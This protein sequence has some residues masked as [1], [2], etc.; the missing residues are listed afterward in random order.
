MMAFSGALF[1]Q[2]GAAA[3]PQTAAVVAPS[4]NFDVVSIR[5]SKDRNA[6]RTHSAPA[7]G[8]GM[9]FTNVP[10][11]MVILTA[12]D[13]NNYTL[14]MGLP[15]WTITD[16]YDVAVKVSEADVAAYH[17]LTSAQRKLMLRRVLEDR[18][19]LNAHLE[20][21]PILVYDLVVAKNGPK[22]K[23]AKPGDTYPNGFKA[24]AG[25]TVL[26]SPPS[27]LVGQGASVTELANRMSDMGDYSIGRQVFDKTGLTGKYDFSLQWTP[28]MKGAGDSDSDGGVEGSGPSLR[29]S[30]N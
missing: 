15:D 2:A 1:A 17:A 20:P 25:Q 21:R 7:N 30:E 13:F 14:T 24:A 11:L 18:L 29:P 8:D 19:K 3:V 6:P 28:Y 9:T 23:P 26:F 5:R 22:M 16:R 4:I 10:M 27:H 12:C